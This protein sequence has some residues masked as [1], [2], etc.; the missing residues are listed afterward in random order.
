MTIDDHI[1]SEVK[2]MLGGITGL[3]VLS[4]MPTA[5][6]PSLP[7]AFC[8]LGGEEVISSESGESVSAMISRR[9]SIEIGVRGSSGSDQL[10]EA[11]NAL[12]QSIAYVFDTLALAA[13]SDDEYTVDQF[14]TEWNGA[15]GIYDTEADRGRF[16]ITISVEYYRTL[17][18]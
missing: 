1:L 18:N 13:Y 7:Y 15:S 16:G 8:W 10:N 5:V 12:K 14:L 11:R 4:S 6:Q 3:T 2:S 17:T 9:I